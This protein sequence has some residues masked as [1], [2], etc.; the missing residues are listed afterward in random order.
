MAVTDD[1]DFGVITENYGRFGFRTVTEMHNQDLVP[2]K[3]KNDDEMSFLYCTLQKQ[4]AQN[5]AMILNVKCSLR[6][7]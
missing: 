2:G 6:T 3:L 1:M 7:N 4:S 5:I